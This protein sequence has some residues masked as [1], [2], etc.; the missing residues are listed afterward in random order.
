MKQRILRNLWRLC[1]CGSV[2]ALVGACGPVN[3]GVQP[4][5]RSVDFQS[6]PVAGFDLPADSTFWR[7]PQDRRACETDGSFFP[8]AHSQTM[9]GYKRG[10]PGTNFASW[11][12]IGIGYYLG[13][14]QLDLAS[15]YGAFMRAVKNKAFTRLQ[16]DA[17]GRG[18]P[19]YATSVLLVSSSLAVSLFDQKALWQAGDRKRVVAWG[20]RL[21]V[22]QRSMR[23][24][25]A[26][27]LIAA[28]A[29]S[30][31][32]WGAVT[33]QAAVFSDGVSGSFGVMAKLDRDGGFEASLRE[34]NRTLASMLL[35]AEVAEQNA[36]KPYA[37]LFNGRTLHS[38]VAWHVAKT[39]V[40][41]DP[42]FP[43]QMDGVVRT[44]YRASG[45]SDQ[46][47]WAPIY[48][49]RFPDGPVAEE[50]RALVNSAKS[51]STARL[52]GVNVGGPTEC[53]WGEPLP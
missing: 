29:A 41:G 43:A 40:A 15:L 49:S 20:N 37:L 33:R 35:A 39:L 52:H 38:A 11:L 46:I 26:T 25:P 34:N 4:D 2:V 23:T 27:G 47:A 22:N 1:L 44:Y 12:G 17:E 51:A 18:S 7:I 9:R 6:G 45:F 8:L 3:P 10:N 53:L 42:R 5:G 21:V 48:L 28:I 31:M 16:F 30:R 24:P 32:A 13:D 19:V 50:L 14:E 36:M